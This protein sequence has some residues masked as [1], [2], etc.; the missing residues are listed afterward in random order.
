VSLFIAL[1]PQGT[2]DPFIWGESYKAGQAFRPN[3]SANLVSVGG[4]ENVTDPA[5]GFYF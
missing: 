4:S 2:G 5:K 3:P 1:N